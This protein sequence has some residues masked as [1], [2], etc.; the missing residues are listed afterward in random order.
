[1][2]ASVKAKFDGKQFLPETLPA[3]EPGRTYL[4]HVQEVTSD[5]RAEK[6]AALREAVKDKA[7]VRDLQDVAADFAIVDTED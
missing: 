7:F 2:A 5:T 1:M 4:L 3:L 6:I